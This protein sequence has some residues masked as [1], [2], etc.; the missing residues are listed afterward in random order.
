MKEQGNDDTG[1]NTDT[2]KRQQNP[3]R[4]HS[5]APLRQGGPL[6]LPTGLIRYRVIGY[7]PG[8]HIPQRVEVDLKRQ[9]AWEQRRL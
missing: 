6:R 5:I 2:G 9:V 1:T 4:M 8:S 7:S 3:A